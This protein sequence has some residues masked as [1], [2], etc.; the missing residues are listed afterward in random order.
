MGGLQKNTRST[1]TPLMA[2]M[3]N[4]AYAGKNHSGK[5]GAVFTVQ[6]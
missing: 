5:P 3:R 1:K 2:A 6:A 4:A